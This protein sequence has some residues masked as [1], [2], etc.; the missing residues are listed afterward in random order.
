MIAPIRQSKAPP[1]TRM[2]Q[3]ARHLVAATLLRRRSGPAEAVPPV[4][5]W[6]AWLFAAWVVVVTGVYFAH[7]LGVF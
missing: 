6:R 3:H 4:P 1:K 5:A 7:M 2:M